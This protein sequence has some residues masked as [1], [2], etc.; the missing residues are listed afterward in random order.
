M[1]LPSLA[2]AIGLVV[3]AHTGAADAQPTIGDTLVLGPFTGHHA[4][5]H[6]DNRQPA[7]EFYGTDLGWT[8]VHKGQ[9]QFLFGDTWKNEKG[10]PIDSVHDDVFGTIDLR[11]WPN[12]TRISAN[13]IPLIKLATRPGSRALSPLDAGIPAE[14]LKTPVG[15]FSDGDREFAV[16][17]TGKPQACRVDDDCAGGFTCETSVGFLGERPGKANGLTLA[18]EEGSTACIADTL[19]DKAD[20]PVQDSG[21]CADKTSSLWTESA[22]GRTSATTME[23]LVAVRDTKDPAKYRRIATWHTNKFINVAMRTVDDFDPTRAKARAKQDYRN[24]TSRTANRRVLLWGRPEFIGV[25][26][27]NQTLS[28]YFA[29]ADIPR[30]PDFT[31]K[32]NYYAGESA[33]GAPRFTAN[34]RD[35]QPID[36]DSTRLG[37]QPREAHDIVQHMSLV[38]LEPLQQWVM[39]YGGGINDVPLPPLAPSCGLLEIFARTECKN[40][41]VGSGAIA[42]RFANDPWGPWSPPQDVFVAGDAKRRPLEGQYAAGGVLHHPDCAGDRCQSRS[43]SL[44]QGDYGWL[45]GANIIEPWTLSDDNGVDVIWNASTWNPYRVILLKTR[46]EK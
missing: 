6:P 27:K 41:V 19:F 12:G 21:V 39:F 40:V 5:L 8:Y 34:E 45:Y 9:L 46:I 13:S 16:F 44:Q 36:L 10:E 22:S 15:G 31:W 23:H 26:A 3:I 25:N 30:E 43:P 7:I 1:K 14:G 29:Y 42:A 24:S 20:K 38:W 35:A 2:T 37:V 33:G 4:P 28:M 11:E 17:I 32:L 18:C